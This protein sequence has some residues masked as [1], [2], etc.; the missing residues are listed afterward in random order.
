MTSCWQNFF[1]YFNVML[2][3]DLCGLQ[4]IILWLL[5]IHDQ[6]QARGPLVALQIFCGPCKITLRDV[7]HFFLKLLKNTVI[8][9]ISTKNL[10][11]TS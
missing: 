9:H 4:W 1:E 6:T 11:K 10:K 2:F 5:N 8:Y 3:A 7:L